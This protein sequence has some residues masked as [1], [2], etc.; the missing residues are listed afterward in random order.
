MQLFLQLTPAHFLWLRYS[1]IAT[2]LSD[3][4]MSR[5]HLQCPTFSKAESMIVSTS[6]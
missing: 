2:K 3:F 6:I 4:S 1:K 5:L